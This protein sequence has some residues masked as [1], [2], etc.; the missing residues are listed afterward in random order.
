[1][2]LAIDIMHGCGPINK[3]YHRLQP[4]KTKARLY[5]LLILQQK[6]LYMLYITNKMERFSFK[7]RFVKKLV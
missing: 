5:L 7:S 1:M 2:T 4:K 6:M 3:M